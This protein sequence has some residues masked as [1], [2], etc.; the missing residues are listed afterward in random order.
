MNQILIGIFG[1]LFAPYAAHLLKGTAKTKEEFIKAAAEFRKPFN[2][3]RNVFDRNTR[4]FHESSDIR[5]AFILY[6][7]EQKRAVAAFE[8]VLPQRFR[9][10]MRTAWADYENYINNESISKWFDSNN[11]FKTDDEILKKR[12]EAI[13]K[14]DRI[15]SFSDYHNIYSILRIPRWKV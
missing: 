11:L 7:T 12:Q 14:I 1:L 8:P 2:E 3:T 9:E 5:E 10:S 13:N 15:L 6:F 4:G